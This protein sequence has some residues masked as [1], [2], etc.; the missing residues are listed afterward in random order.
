MAQT[1]TTF[2]FIWAGLLIA[3]GMI[4]NIGFGTVVDLN[5]TDPAQAES[6]WLTVDSVGNG[7]SGGMEIAGPIWVLLM[8]LAAL[9]ARVLPKALNYVGVVIAVAGL[10]TIVPA[11]EDVGAGFG[12]G[13]IAWLVW[14]GIAMLR[15]SR[16]AALITPERTSSKADGVLA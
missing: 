10:V 13:L 1:G 11:L 2:G 12:V 5:G 6:L 4:T 9:R 7:L 8:S 16:T 15:G 3:A 14:L